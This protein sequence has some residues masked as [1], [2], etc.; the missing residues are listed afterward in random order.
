[1]ERVKETCCG[2]ANSH[3]PF[4]LSLVFPY[5]T[6]QQDTNNR[7]A[8]AATSRFMMMMLMISMPTT[9]YLMSLEKFRLAT[10]ALLSLVL[11]T[12]SVRS[13]EFAD[14][15]AP[16]TSS[17]STPILLPRLAVGSEPQI[18]SNTSSSSTRLQ[19]S[20]EQLRWAVDLAVSRLA[21]SSSGIVHLI[22]L[23]FASLLGLKM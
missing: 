15:A 14:D 5:P 21:A 3:F 6:R 16:L 8:T 9:I 18:T 17:S 10:T 4:F 20:D 7:S 22:L 12:T 19:L 11:L 23:F 13:M 2:S 1:M